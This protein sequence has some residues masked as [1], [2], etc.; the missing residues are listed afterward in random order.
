MF[1]EEIYTEYEDPVAY[2]STCSQNSPELCRTT[3]TLE[4]FAVVLAEFCYS[5]LCN[6]ASQ[7]AMQSA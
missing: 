3:F 5:S 1:C 2:C 4:E 7:N 6:G